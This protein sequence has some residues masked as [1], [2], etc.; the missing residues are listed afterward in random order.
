LRFPSRKIENLQNVKPVLRTEPVKSQNR[1]NKVEL[2][3]INVVV[4]RV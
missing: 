2:L 4:Q 1:V 3:P